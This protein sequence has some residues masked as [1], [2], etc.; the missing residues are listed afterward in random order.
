MAQIIKILSKDHWFIKIFYKFSTLNISK[1]NFELVI[2][3]AKNFIWTTLR[4]FSQYLGYI[5]HPMMP[6]IQIVISRANIVLS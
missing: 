5:L 6:D 2:C 3:I 4:R 1:C